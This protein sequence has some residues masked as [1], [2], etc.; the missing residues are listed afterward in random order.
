[1][2]DYELYYALLD[3]GT[4]TLSF[5]RL[6]LILTLAHLAFKIR[7]KSPRAFLG[8]SLLLTAM[9]AVSLWFALSSDYWRIY[10]TLGQKIGDRPFASDEQ[11][12]KA[13]DYYSRAL[14]TGYWS[15]E[16]LRGYAG[17]LVRAGRGSEAVALLSAGPWQADSAPELVVPFSRALLAAGRP[18]KA[19]EIAS[20]ALNLADEF[21][22]L[23]A[24]RT[25]AEAYM[26]DNK[27]KQAIEFLESCL[28]ELADHE[29]RQLLQEK[30][31][32]LQQSKSWIQNQ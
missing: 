3:N 5:A 4:L 22:R 8:T 13:A 24:I 14:S 30:I 27:P 6:C 28:P 21:D 16:M 19:V 2:T 32:Q 9:A 15:N 10:A 20:F 7:P 26:A 18:Q 29:A 17:T 1:M 31:K 11:L 25:I 23:W 12:A